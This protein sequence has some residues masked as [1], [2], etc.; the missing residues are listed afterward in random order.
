M[1]DLFSKQF[2]QDALAKMKTKAKK[3]MRVPQGRATMEI[4]P[5]WDPPPDGPGQQYP[6][7]ATDAQ[8]KSRRLQRA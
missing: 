7:P 4:T 1:P 5:G 6:S 8:R 2:A 3:P